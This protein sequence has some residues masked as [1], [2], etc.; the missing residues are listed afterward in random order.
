M[1][2]QHFLK[3]ELNTRKPL[4]TQ[5]WGYFVD[6]KTKEILEDWPHN[7]YL[8]HKKSDGDIRPLAHSFDSSK[9]IFDNGDYYF[10]LAQLSEV[11]LIQ[12]VHGLPKIRVSGGRESF[13][14]I[15]RPYCFM[16]Y[17][18]EEMP[19]WRQEFN[20]MCTCFA[21]EIHIA[22]MAQIEDRMRCGD[23][24][25]IY[26][27][28][29]S[30]IVRYRL[31]DHLTFDR[32]QVGGRLELIEELLQEVKNGNLEL[33][34]SNDA[35]K[36][37]HN[38]RFTFKNFELGLQNTP[39]AVFHFDNHK[40]LTINRILSFEKLKNIDEMLPIW[41]KE[42]DA[43]KMEVLKKSRLDALKKMVETV[44]SEK[45]ENRLNG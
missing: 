12:V 25:T 43:L 9:I 30:N 23:D 35:T 20:R 41:G 29:L 36:N 7:Y 2:I 38:Y 45:R 15:E 40:E 4:L 42:T 26:F 3:E 22:G 6:E 5:L 39:N 44:K 10:L 34:Y 17:V 16:K 37:S 27:A 13:G 32:L 19:L 1:D 14:V 28:D 18:N 31:Q 8:G 21:N 11:D 33:A 24:D